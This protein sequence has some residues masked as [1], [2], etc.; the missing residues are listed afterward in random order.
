MSCTQ[1]FVVLAFTTRQ[2]S[3]ALL[4]VSIYRKEYYTVIC[5]FIGKIQL[6]R[7]IKK[8]NFVFGLQITVVIKRVL[9][10]SS[11]S[12]VSRF[13]VGLELLLTRLREWEENAHVGVTL[14][15]HMAAVT[16]LVLDWRRLELTQWRGCLES[17]RLRLVKLSLPFLAIIS[18]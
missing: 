2:C 1:L 4:L 3:D 10:F 7:L 15:P 11:Q 13:L 9:S 17:T 14:G 16:R 8:I 12:P 18:L 5:F 6:K